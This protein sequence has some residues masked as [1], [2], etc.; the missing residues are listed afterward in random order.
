MKNRI[1]LVNRRKKYKKQKIKNKLQNYRLFK[2]N[3][4]KVQAYSKIFIFSDII[5]NQLEACLKQIFKIIFE[6]HI[7]NFKILFIGFPVLHKMK[8]IKLIHFT[9]HD[10]ISEK[11]WISGIFRNRFSI[12]TY[13]KLIQSQNFSKNLKLLLSLK[14]KPHLIV[15]CDH[16]NFE[17]DAINEFYKSGIPIIS[18]NYD[19]LN[20]S[21]ITYNMLGNFDLAKKDIKITYFFLFYS[22]L[23]KIPIL[24]KKQ[25]KKSK[26]TSKR[27]KKIF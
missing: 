10:F 23:K 18:F 12:L 27:D 13:L 14:T 9:N 21:K 1:K 17:T 26:K 24:K 7:N 19:F 11:S 16:Q 8:Q 6:Y 5:L 3:L 15:I 25:P 2:Y 20:I 22:L 4:I